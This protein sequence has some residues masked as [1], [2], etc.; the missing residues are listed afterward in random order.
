V[1][2]FNQENESDGFVF[3]SSTIYETMCSTQDSTTNTAAAAAA[4][5][6]MGFTGR[7]CCLSVVDWTLMV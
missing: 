6:Q 5:E 2:Q 4:A 1:Y 3:F 7:R